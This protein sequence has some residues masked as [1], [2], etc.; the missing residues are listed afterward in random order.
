MEN[1]GP[2][3][4]ATA[5]ATAGPV[6]CVHYRSSAGGFTGREGDAA[7]GKREVMFFVGPNIAMIPDLPPEPSP[8]EAAAMK[9]QGTSP[10]LLDHE[11]YAR[12][13]VARWMMEHS[14]ATGHG[15]TIDD[16]LNELVLQAQEHERRKR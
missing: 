4:R 2:S 8:N 12:E 3:L 7:E 16:L 11:R 6:A 13:A 14:Y 10:G 5:I 15:D 1:A 9:A